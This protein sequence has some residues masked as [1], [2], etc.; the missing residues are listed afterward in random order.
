MF[1]DL[2]PFARDPLTFLLD[3]SAR[4]PEELV[5]LV[6][7][8]KRI[9]L[10]ND[11]EL[12]KPIMQAP[13]AFLCRGR[14]LS[15]S[16]L[17]VGRSLPRLRGEA[18]LMRRPSLH[19]ALAKG[20]V[21]KLLPELLAEI[22][23]AIFRHMRQSSFDA[24]AFGA[25]LALRLVS[26]ALFGRQVVSPADEKALLGAI[27]SV[28]ADV[29]KG[30]FCAFPQSPWTKYAQERKRSR[31][32]EII[33][34]ILKKA[35]ETPDGA[36]MCHLLCRLG[37]PED[38][39]CDEIATLMLAG[40]HATGSAIAWAMYYMATNGWIKRSIA[41]EADACLS[42]DGDIDGSK[43]KSAKISMSLAREALRL[44]PSAWWFSREVVGAHRIGGHD[45]KRGDSLIISPWV[46]HRSERYWRDPDLFD[47]SRNFSSEAYIPFGAGPRARIGMDLT[48][49][50]LQLIML[51]LAAAFE[52]EVAQAPPRLAPTPRV[53]IDPPPIK[54]SL[55]V[56]EEQ[57]ALAQDMG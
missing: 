16:E 12:L 20:I 13:E 44:F 3:K 41:E 46:F 7:G 38:E 31:A 32:R 14:L 15:K 42:P 8:F 25:S 51:D 33:G 52:L 47:L 50:E 4:A 2:R 9:F 26:T 40:H 35:E 45:L 24:H 39:I 54:L 56:R 49:L 17:V 11:A 18:H 5:P 29:S 28:D 21:E 57:P 27:K 23:R 36:R 34:A 43:L 55:H 48:M 22:R 1:S 6:L 37:W 30:M 19:E 53:I 10:V